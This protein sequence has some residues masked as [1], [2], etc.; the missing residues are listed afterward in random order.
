MADR[1]LWRVRTTLSDSPGT[2]ARLAVSCGEADANILALQ[3]FPE[4]DTV[5]DEL[6]VAT[7]QGWTVAQV[8]M[9]FE[10][11]GA[12]VLEVTPAPAGLLG[13]QIVRHLRAAARLAADPRL[14]AEV[15][16][17]LLDAQ[18][19][20]RK[21]TGELTDV[22]DLVLGEEAVRLR[23]TTP[24]TD[25]ERARAAALTSVAELVHAGH[26]PTPA[27]TAAGTSLRR[28]EDGVVAEVDEHCIGRARL[29]TQE[30]DLVLRVAVASPWR[31]RGFGRKLFDEACRMAAERGAGH[32][33]VLV[34]RGNDAA[35]QLLLGSGRCGRLSVSGEMLSG[36]VILS[37]PARATG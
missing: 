17:E 32:V 29:S 25:V 9:L 13:D 2:L 31:G 21:P 30:G 3:V 1:D 35:L 10:S 19:A 6:V 16:A 4:G 34:P 36:R 28:R 5:T 20:G 11:A 27:G 33:V 22:I 18:V 14:L 24:F 15:T 12:G 23:R 37:E 26:A 7:H 8:R